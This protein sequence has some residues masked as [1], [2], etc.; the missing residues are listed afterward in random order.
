MKATASFVDCLTYVD[1][2]HEASCITGQ[3]RYFDS[4]LQGSRKMKIIKILKLCMVQATESSSLERGDYFYTLLTIMKNYRSTDPRDK[5]FAILGLLEGLGVTPPLEPNYK[6]SVC[7]LYMQVSK[8]IYENTHN[9]AFLSLVERN[10]L[11]L[12]KS[13]PDL[14]S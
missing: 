2:I 14:P 5:V 11:I 4:F 10:A 1:K 12:R 3:P 6:I 7:K 8:I 9:L 13:N